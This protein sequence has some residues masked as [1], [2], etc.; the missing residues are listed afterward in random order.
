M[1][2]PNF[3]DRQFLQELNTILVTEENILKATDRIKSTKS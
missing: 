1:P 2:L 3:D